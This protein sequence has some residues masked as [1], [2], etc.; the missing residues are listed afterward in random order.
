MLQGDREA[1]WCLITASMETTGQ[2]SEK[3]G[4]HRIDWA[5]HNPLLYRMVPTLSWGSA[6]SP[7]V[8]GMVLSTM[9]ASGMDKHSKHTVRFFLP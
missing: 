6:Q 7:G 8:S 1:G 2:C 9:A 3:T 5:G 4:I